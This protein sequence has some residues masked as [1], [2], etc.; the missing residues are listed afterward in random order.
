MVTASLLGL[1]MLLIMIV[2]LILR[3]DDACREDHEHDHE[4]EQEQEW[5]EAVYTRF[6][7]A[8]LPIR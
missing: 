8:T 7:N 3:Y 2:L 5:P 6:A 1:F 4:H